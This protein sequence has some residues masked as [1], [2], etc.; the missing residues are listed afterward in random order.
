MALNK[1]A[2]ATKWSVLAEVTAKIATPIVNIILARLLTPDAYGVIASITIITSFA[3]I[4]TDAGFQKYVIQH[5]Y[6]SD[7]ELNDNSNVAFTSNFSLSVLIYILIFIF[8]NKLAIAVGNPDAAN[9]L[10]VAALSVLCTSFSSIVIARFR[11]DLEFKPLFVVRLS[12]ALVPLFVTVPL[13][14]VLRSYWAIVLGTFTQQLFI[15][16]AVTVLS[17]YKPKFYFSHEIFFKM[18]SFSAWNLCESLSIWFAGQANIFIVARVLNSYYLGL[19]R[20]G[21]TTINSYMALFTSAITPVLFSSLSRCQ[22]DNKKFE[23]MFNRFQRLL[24]IIVI[25]MGFGVWMYRKLAVQ[26]LLGSSWVEVTDF[27][28]LWAL[29]SALTIVLSNLACEVYRSK[30]EPKVSFAL[31]VVYLLYYI[32]VIYFSAQKGFE[33]LCMASCLVRLPPIVFDLMT[34][35]IRYNFK[36]REIMHNIL[37]PILASV[38]MCL[39][40]SVLQRISASVVWDFLSIAICVIFYGLIILI[41]KAYRKEIYSL[42]KE[43]KH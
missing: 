2:N 9:G 4:F 27:M 43:R 16:I 42:V 33:F 18:A 12:S 26:I 32:P 15:A 23:T 38:F 7:A 40:A 28:G 11:R 21:M 17:K 10:A 30:G 19:Y 3:D 1:V 22:N 13:A 35:R 14:I 20:T 37:Y 6:S 39:L 5:E 41:N 34:L 36:L 25:P 24:S 29:M 31:Q 8:R